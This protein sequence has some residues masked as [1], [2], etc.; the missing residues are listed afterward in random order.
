M[1]AGRPRRRPV[2]E[3][4]AT[5]P[6]KEEATMPVGKSIMHM[7]VHHYTRSDPVSIPKR[8][9]RYFV[10]VPVTTNDANTYMV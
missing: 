10:Y 6:W 4:S 1:A 2:K 3:A 9:L 7:Y 8:V 5:T